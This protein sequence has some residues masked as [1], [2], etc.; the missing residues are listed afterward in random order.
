MARI[1]SLDSLPWVP[2]IGAMIDA[3]ELKHGL[4]CIR[5]GNIVHS[6]ETVDSTNTL[7]RSF[8]DEG[9]NEGTLV[10]SE[11]QTAG[12][13]RLGRRWISRSGE[14]LTFSLILKPRI[15][16]DKIGLLPLAI[17]VGIAHGIVAST[18]L[19]VRCKWP[20]DLLIGGRKFAGI[21]M[22]GSING[23]GLAFVVVGIGINVNQTAFPEDLS[24]KATSLALTAGRP[25]DRISLFRNVLVSLEKDYDEFIS[26]GFA[27]VL[28]A[29]LEL[30]PIVGTRVAA[31]HQGLVITG[32]V[33][34]LSPEGGLQLQTD[35]GD[36]TL[37]AGDV[38]ILDMES[39]APRN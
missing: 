30:A 29:W 5:F 25:I 34:G 37:F 6:F 4:K 39:Y 3:S 33:T 11:K 20:N 15:P 19:P 12:R 8:A 13:G 2:Y 22:E 21:L 27:S 28:P 38:T 32:R 9:A 1:H 31:D 26:T 36:H 7:A 18:N 10:I 14:N 35:S 23:D 17:A 24:S 16:P